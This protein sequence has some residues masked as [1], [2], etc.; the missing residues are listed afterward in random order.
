MTIIH[1]SVNIRETKN[2]V[3]LILV[4]SL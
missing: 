1:I 4:V 3:S 2:Q